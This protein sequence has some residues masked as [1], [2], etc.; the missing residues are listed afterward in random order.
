MTAV[1][2]AEAFAKLG[3]REF[4]AVVSDIEMPNMTGLQLAERIRR[5]SR[6]E[7]LPI[8]LVTS[9]ATDADRKK[10]AEVGANAYITK[11]TFDQNVLLET[12]RRLV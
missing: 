11:G 9:L 8:I 5:E 10:G 1:D 2:G 3:S 6:Y 4:D 12:L 7:E